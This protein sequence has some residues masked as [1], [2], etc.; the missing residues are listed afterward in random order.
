MKNVWGLFTD[1]MKGQNELEGIYKI[2]VLQLSSQSTQK[3][4]CKLM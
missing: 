3:M 4:L 1:Y 2:L